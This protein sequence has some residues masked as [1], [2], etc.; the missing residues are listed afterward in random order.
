[1]K[2]V[3]AP[4]KGLLNKWL[5]KHAA[6]HRKGRLF[7]QSA[8]GQYMK[9]F[10]RIV[11]SERARHHIYDTPI[12]IIGVT[13]P[14]HEV[15]RGARLDE[16]AELIRK[17]DFQAAKHENIEGGRRAARAERIFKFRKSPA[18]KIIRLAGANPGVAARY[19]KRLGRSAIGR[20]RRRNQKNEIEI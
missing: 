10:F 11:G 12:G 16:L 19:L 13:H 6:F 20:I 8:N 14:T 18:G 15:A 2:R 7:H 17:A 1:M 3:N 5:D 4:K 9:E